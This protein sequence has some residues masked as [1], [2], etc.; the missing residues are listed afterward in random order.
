MHFLNPIWL[1]AV[2]AIA[3]P[4]LIHLWNIRE[5]K[6]LKVGSI[7]IVEASSRK[8]SRSFKL[9]DLLLLLLRCLLLILLAMVLALP[10]FVK[11]PDNTKVKGWLLIPK[12]NL[13]EAYGKFKPT[14]DSLLKAGYAF[15]YFNPGFPSVDFQ[16]ALADT[17]KI[18]QQ[19]PSPY[20]SLLQQLDHQMPAALPVYVIT[21]NRLAN[22]TGSKPEV[23][24]NLHWQTYTP[25]DSANT[26]IQSAWFTANKDVR[27]VTGSSSPSK[28]SFS[29][30]TIRSD[31]QANSLFN[32]SVNNGQPVISLKNSALSPIEI[33]TAL[34]KIAVYADK[35]MLDAAYLKAALESVAQF[36][37]RKISIVP[38]NGYQ[39]IKADWLF[40]LS[41]KPIGQLANQFTNVLTYEN[42]KTKNISS[43]ISVGNV[44]AVSN[45][46]LAVP[47]YKTVNAPP[48]NAEILWHDGFGNPVLS[49]ERSGRNN[50]YHFFSRF[51]PSW[52]DLV[53]SGDFPKMLLTLVLNNHELVDERF[54]RRTVSP[55]QARPIIIKEQHTIQG[56]GNVPEPLTNYCWL[57]LALVF[58]AERWLAHY[59]TNN[60][61]EKGI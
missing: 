54:D 9:I 12:E 7:A 36:S 14:T 31:G 60:R 39:A 50:H 53:W 30:Q 19:K 15:H 16:A 40:W 41:D 33:D 26:W 61:K 45:G 17:A 8:R 34:L 35:N 46:A 27:V 29:T 47:L 48:S 38:F 10:F 44:Y 21:P 55:G 20:W 52:S 22:Y 25:V 51:N 23:A 18:T 28:T 56:K 3:I 1:F 4:V 42:A 43:G 58:L 6:T 5:G 2:A 11:H 37:Q 57:A 59:N 32:V 24:L 13:K 49:V